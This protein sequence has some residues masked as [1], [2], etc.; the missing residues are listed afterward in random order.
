VVQQWLADGGV[1]CC[2]ATGAAAAPM[3]VLEH[4]VVSHREAIGVENSVIVTLV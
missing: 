4:C 2:P 3:R 1:D